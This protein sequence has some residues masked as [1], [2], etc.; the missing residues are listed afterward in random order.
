MYVNIVKQ[1]H[2]DSYK[3]IIEDGKHLL[4]VEDLSL[5]N[6]NLLV[7]EFRIIYAY[8]PVFFIHKFF[9]FLDRLN[10]EEG[11]EFVKVMKLLARLIENNPEKIILTILK[12]LFS[13][14]MTEGAIIDVIVDVLEAL[15]DKY[16]PTDSD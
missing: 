10:E 13:I 7:R 6:A 15:Y 5:H 2:R 11:T 1:G 14:S 16:H 3:V 9:E 8:I 4:I 12:K